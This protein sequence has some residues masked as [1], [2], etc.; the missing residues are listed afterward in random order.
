MPIDL[1]ALEKRATHAAPS[2]WRTT[3]LELVS[4]V[5]RLRGEKE[6]TSRPDPVLQ[7]LRQRR[8]F[9]RLETL[10]RAVNLPRHELEAALERLQQR[11]LAF[12]GWQQRWRA[13]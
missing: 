2:E 13:V 9:W 4:E 10:E 12:K 11:N 1:D 3:V 5:R 7:A 8:H 6:D